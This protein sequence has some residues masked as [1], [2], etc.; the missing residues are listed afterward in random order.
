VNVAKPSAPVAVSGGVVVTTGVERRKTSAPLIVLPRVSITFTRTVTGAVADR[1]GLGLN[2]T[3]SMSRRSG[4]FTAVTGTVPVGGPAVTLL[5][6]AESAVPSPAA[7][8]AVTRTRSVLPTSAER[9]TYVRLIAPVMS[10]HCWPPVL[11]RRH[12]YVNAIGVVPDHSPGFAVSVWFAAGVVS[13]IVGRSVFCGACAGP[14]VPVGTADTSPTRAARSTAATAMPYSLVLRS[15]DDPQESITRDYPRK[16]SALPRESSSERILYGIKVGPSPPDEERMRRLR[17]RL[18]SHVV[19][20]A[21]DLVDELAEERSEQL[22]DLL[23]ELQERTSELRAAE[24][25]AA[26][27]ERRLSRFASPHAAP[28]EQVA[29]LVADLEERDTELAGLRP[30]VE[31]AETKLAAVSAELDERRRT[32]SDL[33]RELD[34]VRAAVADLEARLVRARADGAERSDREREIVARAGALAQRE[35]LL[36]ER[37]RSFGEREAELARRETAVGRIEG[38]PL[39]LG[40][41]EE[42]ERRLEERERALDRAEALL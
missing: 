5:V 32:T 23:R 1:I 31:T 19:R 7:F 35:H 22:A 38:Y 9:T 3:W 33:T 34:A 17:S 27:L 2:C 8:R 36:E 14:A 6:A 18:E 41:V 39:R 12:W 28:D 16:S 20:T 10:A 26:E 15:M 13:E 42:R 37:E 21:T 25:R 29:R 4:G 30:R 11:Q 24:T 40:N